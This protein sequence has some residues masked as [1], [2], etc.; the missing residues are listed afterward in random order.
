M[1]ISIILDGRV[2]TPEEIT[3]LRTSQ[4]TRL[5][6]ARRRKAKKEKVYPQ[7]RRRTTQAQHNYQKA[8]DA[9]QAVPKPSYTLVAHDHAGGIANALRI[10]R[11]HRIHN[12]SNKP[13]TISTLLKREYKAQMTQL[14]KTIRK[15][16]KR[17]NIVST[18]ELKII[19]SIRQETALINSLEASIQKID[20]I[21][22][23]F[24]NSCLPQPLDNPVQ[25]E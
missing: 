10:Q 24:F 16:R 3:L 11:L 6:E 1:T 15:L 8:L 2:Y 18:R 9:Y 7:A 22:I 12:P 14:R 21:G 13:I 25:H 17:I 20:Q 23:E 19:Q 4:A 5:K